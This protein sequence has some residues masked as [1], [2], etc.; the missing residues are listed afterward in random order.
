MTA[1]VRYLDAIG[2]HGELVVEFADHSPDEH[3]PRPTRTG[4]PT[5]S[6]ESTIHFDFDGG[7]KASYSEPE[8]AMYVRSRDTSFDERVSSDTKERSEGHFVSHDG[9]APPSSPRRSE[10]AHRHV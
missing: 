8:S 1:S 2:G 3:R 7:S 4:K 6:T 9:L 5:V 10:A